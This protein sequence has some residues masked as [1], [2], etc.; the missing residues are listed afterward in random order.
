[1]TI[2]DIGIK[3]LAALAAIL[4]FITGLFAFLLQNE[5]KKNLQQDLEETKEEL[6]KTKESN[7]AYAEHK[8][9][10]EELVND[11]ISGDP[12]SL[13]KLMQ[14]NTEAGRKRNRN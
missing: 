8:K 9:E 11:A 6:E 3:I 1:M 13:S 7:K 4:T 2:K 10:T 12:T 14:H 5:K